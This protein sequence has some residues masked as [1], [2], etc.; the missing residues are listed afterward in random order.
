[1]SLFFCSIDFIMCIC[2]SLYKYFRNSNDKD[3]DYKKNNYFKKDFD[4]CFN[5]QFNNS[6]IKEINV[7]N[8]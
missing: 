5:D 2:D 8:I 4:K 3:F 6:I 1:M 7:E